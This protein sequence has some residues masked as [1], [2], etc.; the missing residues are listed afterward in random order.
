MYGLLDSKKFIPI[1]ERSS[2]MKLLDFIK[3]YMDAPTEVKIKIEQLLEAFQSQS[4]S[5]EEP[6]ETTH[7]TQ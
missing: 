4:V 6:A 7:T 5:P 3:L 2:K 1:G